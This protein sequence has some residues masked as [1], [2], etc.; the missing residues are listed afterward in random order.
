MV[1]HFWQP[2][3]PLTTG[4]LPSDGCV[5]MGSAT[6]YSTDS[7]LATRLG[8][9]L[10]NRALIILLPFINH[11]PAHI[12]ALAENLPYYHGSDGKGDIAVCCLRINDITAQ[13]SR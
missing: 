8:Y 10:C 5:L 11:Y 2:L 12:Q 4:L 13:T 3:L 9:G 6:P 7:M 1:K